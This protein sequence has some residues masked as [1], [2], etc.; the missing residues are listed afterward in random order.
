MVTTY[1]ATHM[2]VY[3]GDEPVGALRIDGSKTSPNSSAWPSAR[4]I[5]NHV[6]K[7]FCIFSHSTT[8]PARIRQGYRPRAA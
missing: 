5:A 4:P 7:A 1:Q 3:A 6:L 8:S 2:I